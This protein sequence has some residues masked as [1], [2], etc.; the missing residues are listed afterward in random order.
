[1]ILAATR[2]VP[3]ALNTPKSICGQAPAANAF[4]VNSEPGNVSTDC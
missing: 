1:M 3:W 2:H 4:L